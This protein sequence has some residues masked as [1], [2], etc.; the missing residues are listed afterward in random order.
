[1]FQ[2]LWISRTLG[3]LTWVLALRLY[4]LG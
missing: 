2:G 1:L 4:V 3:G